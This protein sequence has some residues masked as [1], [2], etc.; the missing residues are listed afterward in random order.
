M[1]SPRLALTLASDLPGRPVV[2]IDSGDDIAEIKDVIFDPVSHNL[3]GFTLNKRGWFRGNLKADLPTAS[4][5]AIG[6][7]AVMVSS[8]TSLVG[9]VDAPA[10]LN[11]E[12]EI[13]AV[14]GTR[15]L[16]SAGE[17]LGTVADVVLNTGSSPAAVGYQLDS[18]DGPIF[19][20]ISA[21]LALSG[22]NLILPEHATDFVRHNLADFGA[23]IT[24]YPHAL[25]SSS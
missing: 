20:P 14:I 10:Q 24:R 2:G 6:P 22:D 15:V 5:Y 18:N 11:L 21:Q 3:I 19:V 16:S 1:T 13:V 7:A 23:S 8:T 17:E 12:T 4:V 9:D 25:A